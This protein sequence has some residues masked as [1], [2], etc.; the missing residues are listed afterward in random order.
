MHEAVEIWESRDGLRCVMVAREDGW[1]L[2][3]M[4]NVSIVKSDAFSDPG[5][6][7]S[8]ADAWR[9]QLDEACQR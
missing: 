8:A 1:Q 6:A 5:L 2:C 4:R 9:A 3:L 7:L